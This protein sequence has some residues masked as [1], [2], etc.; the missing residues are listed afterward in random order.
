MYMIYDLN[1]VK[2][3]VT[4]ITIIFMELSTHCS[5]SESYE[6]LQWTESECAVQ[7]MH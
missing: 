7:I 2:L 5:T 1:W 3:N 4:V 6:V